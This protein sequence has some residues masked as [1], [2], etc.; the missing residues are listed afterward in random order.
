MQKLALSAAGNSRTFMLNWN[1]A[2]DSRD[3]PDAQARRLHEL[4]NGSGLH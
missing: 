3:S 2:F 1:N 4:F